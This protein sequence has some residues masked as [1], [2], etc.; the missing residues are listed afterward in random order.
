MNLRQL[1]EPMAMKCQQCEAEGCPGPE[2]L[3]QFA[4]WADLV[5]HVGEETLL[6]WVNH[7]D[8]MIN[9]RNSSGKRY[10]VKQQIL[11]KVAAS[12]LDKDE[13]ERVVQLAAEKVE[14]AP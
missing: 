1:E 7:Y 14:V 13:L 5:D 8:Q 4:N 9:A 2:R 10:R 11:A 12:Y 3:R 6:R